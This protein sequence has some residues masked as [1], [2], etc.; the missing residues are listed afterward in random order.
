MDA[1]EPAPRV[2]EDFVRA[3]RASEVRVSPAEVIDAHQLIHN[4]IDICSD[5]LCNAELQIDVDL[6]A[7][8][9]SGPR[10]VVRSQRAD[11]PSV[12]I[13]GG[14]QHRFGVRDM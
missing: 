4:V 8:D 9:P 13:V 7:H 1:L 2:L 3:L 11:E 12:L 14:S 6:L 5:D 10:A